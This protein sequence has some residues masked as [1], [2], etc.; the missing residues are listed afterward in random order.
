MYIAQRYG[1]HSLPKNTNKTNI[2]DTILR[3][4]NN[5]NVIVLDK[6]IHND[7]EYGVDIITNEIYEYKGNNN[8]EKYSVGYMIQDVPY[9]AENY[10]PN[11]DYAVDIGN[12]VRIEIAKLNKGIRKR[13][14]VLCV[15]IMV[16]YIYDL[17]LRY[18]R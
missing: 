12:A 2:V 17:Y 5:A 13:F 15:F 9:F 8:Y 7:D 4:L 14:A 18:G 16:L 10:I 1:I 6:L 11:V 3:H